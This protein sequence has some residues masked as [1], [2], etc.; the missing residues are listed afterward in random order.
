MERMNTPA[1]PRLRQERRKIADAAKREAAGHAEEPCGFR[2]LDER[3]ID[4]R[5]VGYR[6]ERVQR[7]FAE[8]RRGVL[9][10]DGFQA[11]ELEIAKRFLIRYD[12]GMHAHLHWPS[13]ESATGR[14]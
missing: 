14:L 9:V 5:A 4:G 6:H 12:V 11:I 3:G 10:Q 2:H 8:R 13:A 7:L 1:L